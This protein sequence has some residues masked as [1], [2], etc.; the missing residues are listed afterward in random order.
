MDSKAL[1]GVGFT[2]A[3]T[4]P[5][6]AHALGKWWM[7]IFQMNECR[8]FTLSLPKLHQQEV[9]PAQVGGL[10]ICDRGLVTT[11]FRKE[12]GGG[13]QICRH[14]PGQGSPTPGRLTGPLLVCGLLGTGLNSR[15]WA[16]WP[17]PS[18]LHP[19]DLW[20]NCLPWNWSLLSVRLGTFSRTG[21]YSK[22]CDTLSLL[23]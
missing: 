23:A 22:L 18:P 19:P 21:S 14:H 15:W 3:P 20:K 17:E 13:H 8:W 12:G 5:D 1:E 4:E 6:V 2:A 16:L 7:N 9:I 11:A 10:G